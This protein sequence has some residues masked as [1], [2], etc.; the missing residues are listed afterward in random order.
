[1]NITELGLHLGGT[2]LVIAAAIMLVLIG[3]SGTHATANRLYPLKPPP[4]FRTSADHN[5]DE[6]SAS[7]TGLSEKKRDRA[8]SIIVP[9]R[10]VRMPKGKYMAGLRKSV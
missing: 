10:R 3:S 7:L 4:V 6:V 5:A 2:W 8:I 1:V 9:S